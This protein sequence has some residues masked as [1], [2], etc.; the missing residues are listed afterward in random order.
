MRRMAGVMS[1]CMASCGVFAEEAGLIRNEGFEIAGD[2]NLPQHWNAPKEIYRRDT[3]VFRS[4]GA[5]LRYDNGD[6]K[7]Y[8]LCSQAVK[9]EPGRIYEFSGWVKAQGITGD[10]SGATIC[11]EWYD[12]GKYL[13]GAYPQGVKGNSDWTEVRGVTA[14]IPED[15]KSMSLSCY[16]REGMT[17]TAWWDDIRLRPS[18]EPALSTVLLSP[19]YRGRI[20][21]AGPEQIRIAAEIELRDYNRTLSDIALAWS[22]VHLKDQTEH[23][24]GVVNEVKAARTELAVP[25]QGMRPGR[26]R[27]EVLLLYKGTGELLGFGAHEVVRVEGNPAMTAFVDEHQRLIVDGK[28]FFPLGMYWGAMNKDELRTYAQG[29]FNCLMPYGQPTREQMD[30]AQSFRLKVIYTVKDIYAGLGPAEIKTEAD[31]WAH[32]KGKTEAFSHHPALLAW[33]LN[34]ELGPEHMPRLN[35]HQ[36]WIEQLDP[37]HPSWVVLYQVDQIRKYIDSFDAIGTDPYPIPSGPASNAGEWARRT[38]QGV[39]G[40]RPVW[41]VPQVFNWACYKKDEQKAQFRP[42]TYEEMRCM[43]WQCIAEGAN[44]LVFYSWFDLHRDK[45]A[46]FTE[47]W[48]KVARMAQEIKDRI[49]VLL[50][51]EPAAS[52]RV[53]PC[54]WLRHRVAQLGDRTWLISVNIT[55]EPQT[56]TFELPGAPTGHRPHGPDGQIKVGTPHTLVAQYPP[57]GVR[58]DEFAGFPKP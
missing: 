6:P 17:G 8:R 55:P 19:N 33:Y 18:Q 52:I 51:V 45:A 32:I 44:G 2:A 56:A 28:P 4:G 36:R 27:V 11:V 29:P 25:T 26:H 5:S 39:A 15:A 50:S 10:E 31:E 48:P 9:L 16:V 58:L 35:L 38:R 42:P 54:K 12:G 24:R 21:D 43:A 22:I 37:N 57:F 1:L 14:R 13:G 34:D 40:A 30:L 49:P 3:S 47:Q 7:V 53:P 41:M 23:A 46:P 20:T